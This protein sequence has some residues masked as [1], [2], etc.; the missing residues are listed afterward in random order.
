[1]TMSSDDITHYLAQ[2]FSMYLTE[3]LGLE[4]A[5]GDEFYDPI[6]E[7]FGDTPTEE[8]VIAVFKSA[9]GASKLAAE[10]NS[11]LETEE[12][13]TEMAHNLM[14]VTITNLFGPAK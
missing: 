13:T 4:D 2:D 3:T 14:E 9:D 6:A 8:S 10:L 7:V 11:W 12:V 5:P 1:M